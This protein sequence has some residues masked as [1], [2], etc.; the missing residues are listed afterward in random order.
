MR[1]VGF[2]SLVSLFG[3]TRR[4]QETGQEDTKIPPTTLLLDLSQK[5]PHVVQRRK[6]ISKRVLLCQRKILE[7]RNIVKY[8]AQGQKYFLP[9]LAR[10]RSGR[11]AKVKVE[12]DCFPR[13]GKLNSQLQRQILQK[14]FSSP[15]ISSSWE[16]TQFVFPDSNQGVKV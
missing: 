4:H 2:P 16:K 3:V 12:T 5:L 6:F 10:W 14:Q 8:C 13:E 7:P 9:V 11:A 15:Q 1:R